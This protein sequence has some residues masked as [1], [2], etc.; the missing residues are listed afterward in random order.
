MLNVRTCHTA[1]V[2]G[3]LHDFSSSSMRLFGEF[4]GQ[5]LKLD[6]NVDER[7][8]E[9]IPAQMIGLLICL[10]HIFFEQYA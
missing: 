7:Y 8:G 3:C 6:F 2:A 4:L 5:G 9:E 10:H 1:V